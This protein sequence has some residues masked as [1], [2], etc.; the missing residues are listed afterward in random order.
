MGFG[1]S[2]FRSAA[3][4]T[5]GTLVGGFGVAQAGGAV[6]GNCCS[7]LE[8]RVAEL[9]A[10][11][12]RKGNRKVS[13]KIS[14]YVNKMLLIWD[15]GAESGSYVLDNSTSASRFRFKGSAAVSADL[16]AGFLVEFELA[17]AASMYA[18]QDSSQN[19]MDVLS[20][21]KAAWFLKSK[22]YGKLTVGQYSQATDDIILMSY[23]GT[24]AAATADTEAWN[25]GFSIGNS[26]NGNSWGHV[27]SGGLGL[28]TK[29]GDVVRYDSPTISGF[30]LSAAWGDQ[31][32]WD[33]AL[34][35]KGAF[36]HFRVAAGVG[37][38]SNEG[39]QLIVDGVTRD[40][41]F[42]EIK[43][44]TSV[45][46]VPTGVFLTGAYLGRERDVAGGGS[47]ADSRMYY[48]Q[49]GIK[50]RV[51]ALGATTI[52]TEY[53]NNEDFGTGVDFDGN[54]SRDYASSEVDVWGLGVVQRVD[55]AGMEV[56]AVYRNYDAEITN[57]KANADEED[58]SSVAVGARIKF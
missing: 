1:L 22:K 52:F 18:D 7:D 54:G 41:D 13:L 35:W 12:V 33:V 3:I 28:D 24:G 8:V 5:I 49:A 6:G 58:F 57:D 43:G 10:S 46:H 17:D 19:G 40:V 37:Y 51:L 29:R 38:Y 34:K 53:S 11:T 23:G 2:N 48:I 26:V 47:L 50:K 25:R 55:R 16:K 45:V 15:D 42:N 27:L 21:R 9:E 30:M 31:D 4:A 44:S 56:Y 36:G 39:E 32:V 20:V 14:G